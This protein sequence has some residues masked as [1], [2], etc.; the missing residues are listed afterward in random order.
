MI[1]LRDTWYQAA[2]ADEIAPGTSL[3]RTILDTPILFWRDDAGTLSAILD[4]CPHRFAP[5]SAGTISGNR[6]TCGYH[7]LVFD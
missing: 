1:G 7:A 5:L 6:V 2:W 3:V 4:R